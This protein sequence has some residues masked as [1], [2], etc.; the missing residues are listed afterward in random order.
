MVHVKRV[1]YLSKPLSLDEFKVTT[2]KPVHAIVEQELKNIF[3]FE[4]QKNESPL[5]LIAP[6]GVDCK[7][8]SK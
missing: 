6:G 4:S 7:I 3:K 1:V 5:L 2:K 8:A